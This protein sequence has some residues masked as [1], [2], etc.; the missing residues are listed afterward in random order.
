M[1]TYT[2]PSVA[3]ETYLTFTAKRVG[4]APTITF[5]NGAV[6]GSE[7]VSVDSSN[8]ISVQIASGTSTNAQIKAAI[9]A[10]AVTSGFSA[11]DLV[12]VSITTGHTTDTQ[13]SCVNATLASGLT[14]A[15]KAS[16]TLA[17]L[18]YTAQTAGTAGN[19]IRVKYT[20]GASL[21][22]SVSTNDITV[23]LNNDGT[24]TNALIAAAVLASGPAAALVST[25]SSGE[26][27][28]RVPT[29]DAALAFTNLSG[30]L[31]AAVAT[32]TVQDLTF[33]SDSST[34]GTVD[35]GRT[36]SYTTGAT[37]GAEVVS[38]TSNISVQIENGVSTATQIKAAL[39]AYSPFQTGLACTISGTGSTAQKTVNVAPMTG[40]VAPNILGFFVDNSITALTSS[41][42]YFPFAVR[43][44][45][46]VLHNDETTGA[47]QV[48][49]SWDGINNHG[50][51]DPGESVTLD[52]A[53]MAAVFL[54]YGNGAPV[55]RVF[56][57]GSF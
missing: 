16:L 48:I 28:S 34:T 5:T 8:N 42:V 33:A 57:G 7:V 10:H 29:T 52:N 6:A 19:S 50:I 9:E 22:V 46:I 51:L 17:G 3:I 49:F 43:Y 27:T 37:A 25:A 54:K 4:Q 55:Y 36:I 23:Q 15:V 47:K 13:V 11:S 56:A 1:S 40:A 14:T 30:G 39:D 24:S 53:N 32:L 26:A 31:S 45:T 12:T 38:G 20:S 21:T 41:Y 2:Y 35:N 18:K 44:N